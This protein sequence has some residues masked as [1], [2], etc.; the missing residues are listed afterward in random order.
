MK[1]TKLREKKTESV[2]YTEREEGIKE[3]ISEFVSSTKLYVKQTLKL[4][5]AFFKRLYEKLSTMLCEELGQDGA[6]YRR[7]ARLFF[8]SLACVA[9]GVLISATPFVSGAYPTAIALISSAGMTGS[10]KNVFGPRI[11]VALAL[12]AVVMATLV[13]NEV[14]ILYFTVIFTAF[15]FR[16]VVTHGDFDESIV[17]RTLTSFGASVILSTFHM[18]IESFSFASVAAGVT[19]SVTAPIFTYLFSGLF[20]S[21]G[22]SLE[23]GIRTRA[24]VGLAALFFLVTLSLRSIGIFGFSLSA[25]FAFLVTLTVSKTLGAMHGGVF[26]MITGMGAGGGLFAAAFGVIGLFSAMFFSVSDFLTLAVSVV[27]SSAVSIYVSGFEGI[28]SILPEVLFGSLLVYPI[29]K[30]LPSSVE[31][32]R[33]ISDSIKTSDAHERELVERKLEKMS[34]T[35]AT[36]SEVFYAVTDSL[37]TPSVEEVRISVDN[38]MNKVCATCSMSGACWSKFYADS[39]DECQRLAEILKAEGRVR[40]EDF[41][42]VFSERCGKIERIL[43]GIN[44]RHRDF[45]KEWSDLSHAGLIAGEYHTVARLLQGTAESFSQSAKENLL[46][47]E[48]GSKALRSLGIHFRRIEAWG[49]RNSVIDVFG[50]EEEKISRSTE[51]IISAFESE[52]AMFFEE[53]EFIRLDGVS[54]MR[55]RRRAPLTLE[56]AKKS[57]TKKGEKVN[58]DT[59]AFFEKDG[60]YFYA[61]ISDGMG[62]GRDAALTSRLA[63]I[64]LE[65]LLTCTDDKKT[66]LE[67]LNSLIIAKKDECFTTLDL[68][69]FDLLEMKASFL[70]AGAAPSFIVREDK[71]YKVNSKTPP[72]GII[73]KLSAEETKITV[74]DGDM[75]VLLS[76]G[77]IDVGDVGAEDNPWLVELLDRER[78][79]SAEEMADAILSEALTRFSRSDD[80]S[81]AVVKAHRS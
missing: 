16:S 72:A 38:A 30:F 68:L 48:R 80:M 15:I 29:L 60:G 41:S 12:S 27:V 1:K 81:V 55:L 28:L 31:R 20:S 25:V 63:S 32:I 77:I 59:V 37:K 40:K 58:G 17:F 57:C 50:V 53:P 52:C 78:G 62:S 69:E 4:Y 54:V 79:K 71:V 23:S 42:E 66:T 70:K 34:G 8:I 33:L 67:M 22:E 2:D 35:F 36:L 6:S 56:C 11:T 75:I 51:E 24:E 18:I 43:D 44:K 10:R 49:R 64:F 65:K 45:C 73:R 19:L 39:S 46:L 7:R 13:M 74:K 9:V 47:G 5:S 3:E 76:D 21:L 61:L 14:G 26:G